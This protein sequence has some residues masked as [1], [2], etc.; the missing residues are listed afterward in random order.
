[1][2]RTHNQQMSDAHEAN[3]AE[4]I[5][6]V[7]HKGSGNQ[8]S[9]QMDASNDE[10]TPYALAAD[11]KAT[12]GK[13]ISVTR[14]MWR[15]AVE[16]T[17]GKIPTLWLRF[18]KDESLRTVEQDLVVLDRRDF[19]E[20]LEAARTYRQIMQQHHLVEPSSGCDCCR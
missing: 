2:T 1:M 17:F 5:G 13:G 12:L 9:S 15:K 11:G 4:W 14:E 7:Q 16:Q 20:I 18:Y 10:R 6:G 8:W 3:I 19:V